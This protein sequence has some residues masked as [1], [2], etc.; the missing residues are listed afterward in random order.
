MKTGENYQ[1]WFLD[2]LQRVGPALSDEQLWTLM[3]WVLAE[4]ARLNIWS[5]SK[6]QKLDSHEF[7]IPADNKNSHFIKVS[8]IKFIDN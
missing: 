1:N 2:Q 8:E 4:S 3:V 5:M 7:M 6:W